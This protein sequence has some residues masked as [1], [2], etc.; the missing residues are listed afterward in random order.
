MSRRKSISPINRELTKLHNIVNEKELSSNLIFHDIEEVKLKINEFDINQKGYLSLILKY[1]TRLKNNQWLDILIGNYLENF[2]VND[3][4]LLMKYYEDDNKS[5]NNS[6]L[7][8]S[9]HYK[10]YYFSSKS[11]EFLINY[12]LIK[13]LY[14]LDGYYTK[15]DVN[16]IQNSNYILIALQ[17]EEY[18]LL[19]NYNNTKNMLNKSNRNS[20][21]NIMFFN[22]KI[23]EKLNGN[24][25]KH[26]FLINKFFSNLYLNFDSKSNF[27]CLDC[28]NILHCLGGEIKEDSYILLLNILNSLVKMNIIPILV[29]HKRHLDENSFNKTENMRK[30]IRII[31]D[32]YN[33]LILQTPYRENDDYFI[34]L[35]SFVH[36]YKI[37]TKDTYGDHSD[38]LLDGEKNY[39]YQINSYIK[40]L[41]VD[42]KVNIESSKI[43]KFTVRFSEDLFRNYS[44]C[45][46]VI[47]ESIYIPGI[48]NK[49]YK[50]IKI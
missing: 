50:L 45:I 10:N 36:G 1:L 18:N 38:Y 21:I 47:D 14:C 34:F 30:I 35:V 27:V 42:Y 39:Y 6:D 24:E 28:G 19:K 2:R 5:I 33:N 41:L 12:N 37:I 32:K 11:I 7:F 49:F 48:D 16:K 25:S 3:Y 4:L 22:E 26:R 20:K 8:F 46:Q 29:I 44:L 23:L 15:F 40:D 31:L 17:S 9:L 13:F 43:D